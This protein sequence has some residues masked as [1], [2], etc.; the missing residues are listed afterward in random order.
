[1][2]D[3]GFDPRALRTSLKP[4]VP[5]QRAILTPQEDR[6][7]R[8]YGIHFERIARGIEHWFG[9]VPSASHEIAAHCGGRV[10]RSARR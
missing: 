9:K 2:I 10:K 7:L 4:L 6:Y 1:M 3:V 5:G 8:H